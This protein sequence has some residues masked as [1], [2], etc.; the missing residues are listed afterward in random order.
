MLI[1]VFGSAVFGVEATTVTV[2][3]NID[4]G[5]GYHLVGLPDNAIRESSYRIAA[6][7]Q[8]TGFKLPGKKIT[9]NLAPADLRK[10]GSAYDLTLAIGILAASGQIKAHRVTDYMIMGELSLDGDLQ[11]IKGALPI[12]IKAREEG[13]KGFILPK[14]N[15]KEAAVVDNLMVY[16]IGNIKDVIRFFNDEEGLEPTQLDTR[17][18]FYA[19]LDN[20]E[21]D[22]ADVKGQESIKRCMEIA[23]AG[24]HN[25][26]LV[27]PPGSGKTMLSKRLPS[28]LPPMSLQEALETTKIHSVAGRIKDNIGLMAQ[29]PFR[30]PHHTISDVALVGGGAY[31]QPGEISLCHNGVLFLDELP[32]F[33]RSVLE[34][35][36]QPLEDREVTISRAKFT[37][38]Y[39]SS[40]MLVASMNP[41]PGGY[42]ND[43][44]SPV[45]SSPAEMQRYLSKISGPLLDRIDIHIEV[46]P[47]PFD[48]LSEDRKGER[49]IEIRKRVILA[50]E[51]QSQRFS[52]MKGVHYN[53]QMGVQQIREFCKLNTSSK[54]LLKT[55]ME[56]LHL[57]ARAYDRILKV[58]R[59]IADLETTKD[60][61]EHHIS[62]AIQYRSLDRD[63][64]L[65]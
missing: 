17:D 39:P 48:K 37:V 56:R 7:L 64:W 52:K 14:Q 18:E 31:P 16:G 26:I 41:S 27:G 61:Q 36:R 29:R 65:G 19:A 47:V 53:A 3:V 49:S 2:E 34:V 63:G 35:M 58:S 10:E 4:K 8:N 33:K 43:P 62:E 50:R 25:I 28:I 46:T 6:A 44:D 5:I 13:F 55:A 15:A 21:Y 24:G 60:I 54:N 9:I 22:F 59:T 32:E 20:P 30:S 11:P 57:S 40:F 45:T 1:K 51:I 42:F 23:A 12:A 38:T